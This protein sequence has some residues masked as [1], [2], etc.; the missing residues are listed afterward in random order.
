MQ[1]LYEKEI[2][3]AAGEKLGRENRLSL[4]RLQ[5]IVV[6]MGVGSAITDKKHL[7]EAVGG[8]GGDHRPEAAVRCKSRKSIADFRLA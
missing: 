2:L 8:H 1:T 4:P 5:K 6:S 7:E 3:P